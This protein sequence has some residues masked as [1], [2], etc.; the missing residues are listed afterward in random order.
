MKKRVQEG[1][2]GW[3]KV[4][5][6]ICDRS[7]PARVRGKMYKTAMLYV[8]NM[9]AL[10]KNQKMELEVTEMRMLR[11]SLRNDKA[12]TELTASEDQKV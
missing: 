1:W 4:S 3:R 11:F 2:N 5:E 12:R 6:V 9:L 10:T 8:L 7:V